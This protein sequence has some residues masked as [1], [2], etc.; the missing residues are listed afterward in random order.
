MG[1]TLTHG[2]YLPDKGERNCYSGLAGNWT[3]LD[4]S[5][6][7]I[8]EHT[9]Q[10]AGKAPLVHTHTKSDITDFPAYGNTAGTI[11][12]GNDSRLSDA[13]T[14]V[15]HTHGKADITDLFNS[16]NT[17]SENNQ[18]AK[19]NT[20]ETNTVEWHNS[21]Y[22][23]INLISDGH[24]ANMAALLTAIRN[25]D[26]SDI[27]IGD[28]VELTFTYEGASRT[29][30]FY[31]GEIDKFYNVGN[32]NKLTTHHL[33]MITGD[34]GSIIKAMNTTATTEGGYVGSQA[35][36]TILPA[37]YNILN[38]LFNNAILTHNEWLP[39]AIITSQ[40]I[41]NLSLDDGNGAVTYICS[42][43][44]VRAGNIPNDYG[45]ASS[46]TWYSCN[47]VLMSE[48]EVYGC[49]RNSCGAMDDLMSPNGQIAVFKYNL[50][51]Q[52]MNGNRNYW[53]RNIATANKFAYISSQ[54]NAFSWNANGNFCV[55][56]PRFLIG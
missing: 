54:G 48:I 45:T 21:H 12:E 25:Q 1:Q 31:V 18:F 42:N 39:N 27:Y 32:P 37:L 3:I 44:P 8:A 20:I 36:T 49:N 24:F 7:S 33:V 43:F 10:I 5:V 41:N 4:N 34:M 38:P 35:H 9:S 13:R 19:I 2:V 29:V 17:W 6:G 46:G 51:L 50:Q 47:L 22:R 56:R 23:G 55:I 30:K 53:L 14:P 11:C 40:S 26:W 15:A 52:N 28:Y 16:A